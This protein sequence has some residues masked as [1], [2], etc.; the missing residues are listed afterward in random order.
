MCATLVLSLCK[1]GLVTQASSLRSE[2][3]RGACSSGQN[4]IL[5]K[6]VKQIRLRRPGL[7]HAQVIGQ[8]GLAGRVGL[9]KNSAAALARMEGNGSIEDRV[10]RMNRRGK[11]RAERHLYLDSSVQGAL[12]PC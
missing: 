10:N 5:G 6:P 11:N 4:Q 7:A 2:Y 3:S 9:S 1:L 12:V 8:R